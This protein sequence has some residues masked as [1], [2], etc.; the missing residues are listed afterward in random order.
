MTRETMA[1]NKEFIDYCRKENILFSE[2]LDLQYRSDASFLTRGTPFALVFPKNESEVKRVVSYAAQH[3][4]AITLR[5]MGSSTAGAAL[6]D[7]HSILMVVDR[8]GVCDEWGVRQRKP[9]I[10]IV[11]GDLQPAEIEKN[12]DRELYAVVGGGLST[13]ELDRYLKKMN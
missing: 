3:T 8:L 11:G 5:A 13:S 6:A 12:D 1:N 10:K 7:E 4:L 2:N 9:K